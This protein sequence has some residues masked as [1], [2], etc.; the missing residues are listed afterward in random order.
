MKANVLGEAEIDFRQHE[1]VVKLEAKVEQLLTALPQVADNTEDL[2]PHDV[3]R[4]C[5][6]VCANL[7]VYNKAAI[8]DVAQQFADD[9][10]RIGLDP[11]DVEDLRA[12]L[13]MAMEQVL[14]VSALLGEPRAEQL[15]S[16][17][18]TMEGVIEELDH[19]TVE[20]ED[21]DEESSGDGPRIELGGRP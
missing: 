11:A 14:E 20:D 17:V 8:L 10:Y 4:A 19:L 9:E 15:E 7:M 16:A 2:S 18:S 12:R 13:A 6:E 3:L 5:T 21:E 1:S